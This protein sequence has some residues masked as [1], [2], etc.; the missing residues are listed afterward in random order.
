MYAKR[1]RFAPLLEE[2]T[3][4]DSSPAKDET[5][6]VPA[7]RRGFDVPSQERRDGS[8]T[9]DDLRHGRRIFW[10]PA[11]HRAAKQIVSQGDNSLAK[12]QLLMKKRQ[13]REKLA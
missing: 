12:L 4:P 11:E 10:Q 13:I 1:S 8:P 2:L 5:K 3:N 7:I 6:L 9:K